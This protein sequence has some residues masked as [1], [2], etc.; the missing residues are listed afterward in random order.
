M[1]NYTNQ[2]K[3]YSNYFKIKTQPLLLL[4][5][6]SSLT[7]GSLNLFVLFSEWN[8]FLRE[9]FNRVSRM[10]IGSVNIRTMHKYSRKKM[11]QITKKHFVF[12][13][14]CIIPFHAS[15]FFLYPL[16]NSENLWFSDVFRRY[17]KKPEAWNRITKY[18][19]INSF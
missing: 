18:V 11:L 17:R 19:S 16:E 13:K 15:S 7:W 1:F 3:T 2:W 12:T 8:S 5:I 9:F 6:N 14:F 10:V 4:Q